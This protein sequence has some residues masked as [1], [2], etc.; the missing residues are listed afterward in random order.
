MSV[1]WRVP[2]NLERD[3]MSRALEWAVTP[4]SHAEV[5]VVVIAG[6]LQGLAA[7]SFAAALFHPNPIDACRLRRGNVG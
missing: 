7:G 6:L 1:Q 4:G 5:T 2:P 3:R